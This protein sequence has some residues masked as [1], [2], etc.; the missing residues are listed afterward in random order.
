MTKE[1]INGQTKPNQKKRKKKT[2][3]NKTQNTKQKLREKSR[4]MVSSKQNDTKLQRRE[5]QRTKHMT[6]GKPSERTP[7]INE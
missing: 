5:S 6:A 3:Q 1:T 4:E 7:D 2:K